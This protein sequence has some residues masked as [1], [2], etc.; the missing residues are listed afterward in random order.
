MLFR[1]ALWDAAKSAPDTALTASFDV[2]GSTFTLD[3]FPNFPSAGGGAAD[4]LTTTVELR[5]PDG[6]AARA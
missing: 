5:V 2:N 3:V 4:V 6:E 1:S